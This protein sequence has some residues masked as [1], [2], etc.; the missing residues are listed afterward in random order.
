MVPMTVDSWNNSIPFAQSSHLTNLKSEIDSK[1]Q[2]KWEAA[3][4]DDMNNFL[5][6]V[7]VDNPGQLLRTIGKSIDED[8]YGIHQTPFLGY[9]WETLKSA[10]NGMISTHNRIRIFYF[11]MQAYV[12]AIQS[13]AKKLDNLA[14]TGTDPIEAEVQLFEKRLVKQTERYRQLTSKQIY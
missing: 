6:N 11:V 10:H 4:F 3:T 14:T 1:L 8:L 7:S 5:G 12:T 9:E 2:S 13:V